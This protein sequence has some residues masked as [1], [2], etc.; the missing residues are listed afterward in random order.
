MLLSVR[1]LNSCSSV[2]SWDWATEA[3]WTQGDSFSWYFQLID[4]SRDSTRDGFDPA[5]RRYAP[6][7][8]AALTATLMSLDDGVK[9]VR[10]ASQPFAQDPSIWRLSV[11]STDQLRGTVDLLLMLS[12]GSVVTRGR[13]SAAACVAGQGEI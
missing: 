2:N 9:V 12:E 10:T 1:T 4:L 7:A 13:A 5:G 11:L 6:A 3:T 8:G